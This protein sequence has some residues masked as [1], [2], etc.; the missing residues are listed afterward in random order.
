MAALAETPAEIVELIVL[1][2]QLG[3]ESAW[4]A[5][6]HGGPRRAVMYNDFVLVGPSADP[7]H[8][9]GG[10]ELHGPRP[11]GSTRRLPF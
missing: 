1:A 5:E 3:Y 10:A 4:V 9:G 11:Q 2:E 8:I 7:A 6:G